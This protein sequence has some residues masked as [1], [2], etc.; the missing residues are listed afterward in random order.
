MHKLESYASEVVCNGHLQM[1]TRQAS[2]TLMTLPIAE[3]VCVSPKGLLSI[4]SL[5]L[6]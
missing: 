6:I 3:V 5:I 2:W 4:F 1:C